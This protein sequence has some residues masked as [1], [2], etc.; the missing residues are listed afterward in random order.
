M[1]LLPFVLATGHAQELAVFG[2]VEQSSPTASSITVLGQTYGVTPSVAV[3]IGAKRY[4]VA[5]TF[6]LIRSGTYVSI[7]GSQTADGK[8]LAKEILVSRRAYVPGASE[9]FVSGLVTA[10]DISTGV[11]QIGPLKIDTTT[12]LPTNSAEAFAVGSHIEATGK[13]ALPGGV[14]WV[15][16]LE[17]VAPVGLQSI[18]GTGVS[19]QSISGTGASLQSI[20][21]T[22]VGTQ[23]ISGTGVSALSISGTGTSLQSISG[24]GTQSISGT[25]V[26]ALSIS[27][28]GTSLQSISGT[29]TQSISGTGVSALSISGTGTSLQS[30]SGTG[31]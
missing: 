30:I 31:A 6:R 9:V 26:S 23:S 20:S 15:S 24:T 29:G 4:S 2:P 5:E 14:L 27:G 12:F 19:T 1:F 18:S 10:F 25:G 17:V 28:T 13:Q 7:V 22:G 16:S 8:L 3:V 21:G 11:A